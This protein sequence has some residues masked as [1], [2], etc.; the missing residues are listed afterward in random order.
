MSYNNLTDIGLIDILSNLHWCKNLKEIYFG[1]NANLTEVGLNALMEVL[2]IFTQ[3]RILGL[4]NS[5][6]NDEN[7]INLSYALEVF[8]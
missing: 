3:L 4:S 5:S 2:P 7:V 6:M 8:K 1:N